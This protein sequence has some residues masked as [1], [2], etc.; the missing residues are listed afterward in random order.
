MAGDEVLRELPPFAHGELR[1]L[2]RIIEGLLPGIIYKRN[3]GHVPHG[4]HALTPRHAHEA[5]HL[6]AAPMH[7]EAERAD[8]RVR[9]VPDGGDDGAGR[10][11]AAIGKLDRRRARGFGADDSP[12]VDTLNLE[13]ALCVS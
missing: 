11:D 13:L 2:W 3:I 5:V 8:K 1:G 6:N 10:N 12:D 7:V 4:P 9:P